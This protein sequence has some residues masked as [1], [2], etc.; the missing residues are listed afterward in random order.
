MRFARTTFGAP[1]ASEDEPKD[2]LESPEE[3]LDDDDDEAVD[4]VVDIGDGVR[5]RTADESLLLLF[6]G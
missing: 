5:G 4:D 2:D 6:V 1:P 3:E